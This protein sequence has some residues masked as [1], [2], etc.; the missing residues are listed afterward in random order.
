MQYAIQIGDS[1]LLQND[2]ATLLW[3]NEERALA[4]KQE[5]LLQLTTAENPARLPRIQIVPA[6]AGVVP[7]RLTQLPLP[8]PLPVLPVPA[9]PTVRTHP[10][11][12]SYEIAQASALVDEI[13]RRGLEV[14]HMGEDDTDTPAQRVKGAGAVWALLGHTDNDEIELYDGAGFVG[15]LW[16][17]Y[18]NG[19]GE[20][21][22][23]HTDNELCNALWQHVQDV[24]GQG[25]AD[26]DRR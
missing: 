13:A 20:L 12:R 26:D 21:I 8:L 2:G 9:A 19:P 18:G 6:P 3:A 5:I 22:A 4:A 15:W 10:H 17:V 23:D 1:L 11:M 14:R 25:E 16:L 7:S 24:T